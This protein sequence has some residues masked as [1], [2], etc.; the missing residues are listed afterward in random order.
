MRSES[1]LSMMDPYAGR[2]GTSNKNGA[3]QI[4]GH[5]FKMQ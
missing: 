4:L 3:N 1:P 5:Q 2:F